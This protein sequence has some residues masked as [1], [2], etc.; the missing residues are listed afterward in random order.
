[1]MKSLSIAAAIAAAAVPAASA[2]AATLIINV[3]GAQSFG[4]RG[5]A[6]N[7]VA[8]YLL[9]AGAHITSIS[10][11]VTIE[12]FSPSWLSEAGIAFTDSTPI[13][14]GV[15]LNPG[16][17]D[18]ISGTRTYSDTANL[19][20]LGL[21]FFLKADGLLRTE[22]YEDFNDSA[23]NPDAI[24]RSGTITITYD[25]AS[26]AVPEPAT[27]AMMM[28]GFGLLG[29]GMRRRTTTRVRYAV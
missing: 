25:A 8:T 6:G 29:A 3:A 4:A 13:T 19:V 9:G 7:Q 20:A 2:N 18:D 17:A 24:W 1:M 11:N 22:F 14:D 15:L 23:V 10:Y 5:S 12:A 16:I 21:D 28:L 26:A 27:W